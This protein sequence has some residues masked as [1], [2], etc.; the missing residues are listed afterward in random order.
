MRASNNAVTAIDYFQKPQQK[1]SQYKYI[2]LAPTAFCGTGMFTS[3]P[4]LSQ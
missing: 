4:C 2:Y 1:I 3:R